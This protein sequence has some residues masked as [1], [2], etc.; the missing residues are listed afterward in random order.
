MPVVVGVRPISPRA[1]A[2]VDP[3]KPVG[4]TDGHRSYKLTRTK[5]RTGSL[6]SQYVAKYQSLQRRAEVKPTRRT[7]P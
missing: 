1:G 7:S 3:L 5:G 6:F 4:Q 2:V